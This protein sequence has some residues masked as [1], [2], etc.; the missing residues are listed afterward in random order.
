MAIRTV[1]FDAPSPFQPLLMVVLGL[2]LLGLRSPRYLLTGAALAVLLA[3]ASRLSFA[4]F[5]ALPRPFESFSELRPLSFALALKYFGCAALALPLLAVW[6][7]IKE[8]TET[9]RL[10][11][12]WLLLTA[13]LALRQTRYAYHL[14]LPAAALLGWGAWAAIEALERR[15]PRREVAARAAV[16]VLAALLAWPAATYLRAQLSAADIVSDPRLLD[17]CRWIRENTPPTRSLWRDEGRP[18]YGV[19][20]LHNI[21]IELAALAQR[22]ALAGNWHL[23]RAKVLESASFFF[24][25]EENEAYRFLLERGFRY[26]VLDDMVSTGA[27]ATYARQLGL[28]QYKAEITGPGRMTLSKNFQDLLYMRLYF[29]AAGET[30][31]FRRLY[32]TQSRAGGPGYKVF[33]LKARPSAPSMP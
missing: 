18:E 5:S 19:F 8:R 27:L 23:Q 28:S 11:L 17:V 12:I 3:A 24:I 10:L 14:S 4:E 32:E 20:A 2:C 29:G 30:K 9:A 25:T 6:L 7:A 26:I 13:V 21:G 1:A 16:A 15:W 31:H 22:P 33:E